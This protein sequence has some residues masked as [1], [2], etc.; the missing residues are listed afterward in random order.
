MKPQYEP[1]THAQRLGLLIEELGE[2]I[3]AAGKMLRYGGD[4]VNPELEP[5]EPFYH[6]TNEEWLYRELGDVEEAV[7]RFIL[8][9][10]SSA[11]TVRELNGLYPPRFTKDGDPAFGTC[12]TCSE[13]L[14]TGTPARPQD[15]LQCRK[16]IR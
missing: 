11:P 15:D 10:G 14:D 5:G 3:A 7:S 16:C 1:K 8:A 12:S 9:T 2:A 6:E 4:S 13:P